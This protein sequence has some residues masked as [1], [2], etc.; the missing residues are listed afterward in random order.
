M[1][2]KGVSVNDLNAII[3]TYVVSG[4]RSG[5][6]DDCFRLVAGLTDDQAEQDLTAAMRASGAG[7]VLRQTATGEAKLSRHVLFLRMYSLATHI[8]NRSRGGMVPTAYIHQI[9]R[10]TSAVGET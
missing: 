10:Q 8:Q 4:R 7:L 6:S 2:T 9:C 3:D 1:R 5:H